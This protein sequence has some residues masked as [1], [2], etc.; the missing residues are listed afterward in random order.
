MSLSHRLQA[1]RP[2]LDYLVLSILSIF[3]VI[4][5]VIKERTNGLSRTS[6]ITLRW[7]AVNTSAGF[8]SHITSIRSSSR[9]R[10]VSLLFEVFGLR[11]LSPI[12]NAVGHRHLGVA[13]ASYRLSGSRLRPRYCN[14][15][16]LRS[17]RVGAGAGT[18]FWAGQ[19][20]YGRR[21]VAAGLGA[22]ILAIERPRGALTTSSCGICSF[23]NIQWIHGSS[24]SA[25]SPGSSSPAGACGVTL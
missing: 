2:R 15:I 14:S 10:G 3:F 17:A 5:L 19:F 25:L 12:C 6:S 16:L 13:W 22:L 1:L 9:R 11:P 20:Q 23:R 7:I 21:L 4:W 18:L 8:W 24:P